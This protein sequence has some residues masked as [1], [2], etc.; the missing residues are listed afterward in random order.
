M[1]TPALS[2]RARR[3]L[4]EA[5]VPRGARILVACSGGLD[6]QVLLDVLAHLS[7]TKRVEL[8]AHGVDHGLRVDATEELALAARLSQSRGVPF[9][10][11]RVEV[12]S[13]SNLQARARKARWTALETAA[14]RAGAAFVATGHHAD[15]RAETVLIRLVRGAPLQGLAVLPVR[16]KNRL[17]P[18]IEARKSELV[19]HAASRNIPFADDPSNR[20][21]RHLRVRVRHE[22]LPLLG[23]LDPR[24]VEHLCALADQAAALAVAGAN[25]SAHFA[26]FDPDLR[27]SSRAVAALRDAVARKNVRARVPLAGGRVARWDETHG[28]VITSS[29]RAESRARRR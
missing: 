5:E 28:I 26:D 25:P 22:L 4:D 7:R 27:P 15:D 19:A 21:R 18:L 20:D 16:S 8:F 13:G 14:S 23:S 6:S 2:T 9:S 12:A 10:T 24:I 3:A 29:P 1:T 11:S 17:R